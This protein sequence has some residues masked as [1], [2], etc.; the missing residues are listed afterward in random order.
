MFESNM[1]AIG[2]T[3]S[4]PSSET[5]SPIAATSKTSDVVP[6][7]SHFGRSGCCYFYI[8]RTGHSST[9]TL[10]RFKSLILRISFILFFHMYFCVSFF[11]VDPSL[12]SCI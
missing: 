5:N 10:Q 9:H 2:E 7:R 8:F 6:Y 11:S 12:L 4:L 1:S 3:N